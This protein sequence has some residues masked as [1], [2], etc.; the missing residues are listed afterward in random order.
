M[1]I[2][3]YIHA[4]HQFSLLFSLANPSYSF[5]LFLFFSHEH[6]KKKMKRICTFPHRY[7]L[8]FAL[9]CTREDSIQSPLVEEKA[10]KRNENYTSDK[11]TE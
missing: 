8:F 7:F 5:F 9:I 3:L 11:V 10:E 4:N 6:E 1:N 2:T